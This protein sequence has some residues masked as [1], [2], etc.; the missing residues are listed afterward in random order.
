MK[1]NS[2]SPLKYQNFHSNLKTKKPISGFNSSVATNPTYQ[3]KAN[4]LSSRFNINFSSLGDFDFK[5]SSKKL[6]DKINFKL[7]PANYSPSEMKSA[8]RTNSDI[9]LLNL[10]MKADG[11]TD[12]CQT[13]VSLNRVLM[14]LKTKS[15]IA[16]KTAFSR[17][18]KLSALFVDKMAV[19]YLEHLFEKDSIAKRNLLADF[20]NGQIKFYSLNTEPAELETLQTRLEKIFQSEIDIKQINNFPK[21]ETK[22]P[23]CNDIMD[24]LF[25]MAKEAKLND[26]EEEIFYK[27]ALKYLDKTLSCY[28][29]QSLAKKMKEAYSKIE[30]CV[31]SRG[32]TMDDVYYFI[33]NQNKSHE[34]INYLYATEN[35]INSDKFIFNKTELAKADKSK[36]YVILDDC[37]LSG[38]SMAEDVQ[39]FNFVMNRKSSDVDLMFC[40][41]L[42]TKHAKE[43]AQKLASK[44]LFTYI[45]MDVCK[46]YDV[47]E[48]NDAMLNDGFSEEEIAVLKKTVKTGFTDKFASIIFPYM[49]PDNSSELVGYLGSKFLIDD[50]YTANKA[51]LFQLSNSQ[52][53]GF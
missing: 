37:A 36:I 25:A 14:Y 24:I 52:G 9:Q 38:S 12:I 3:I 40:S 11:I 19:D 43:S 42:T 16:L 17:D 5:A 28:S 23:D 26:K 29:Y 47:S 50:N 8:L 33:P 41:V 45:P 13:G 15:Q 39:I 46:T 7:N 27:A 20:N 6:E 31:I 21:K 30:Q 44:S 32:K 53:Y 51:V 49:I 34:V 35:N 18:E 10:M 2:L 22:Y 4:Q 48:N 1:V